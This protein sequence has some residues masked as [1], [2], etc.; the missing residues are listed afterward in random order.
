VYFGHLARLP[1]AFKTS[2]AEEPAMTA[3]FRFILACSL[4]LFV[5]QECRAQSEGTDPVERLKLVLRGAASDDWGRDEACKRQ[6]DSLH[7]IQDLHRALIL[8]EWRDLD[9][10]E[11]IAAIDRRNRA[12]IAERFDT[13][14]RSLLA[15]RNTAT[16]LAVLKLIAEMGV[17]AREVGGTSP[18]ARRFAPELFAILNRDDPALRDEA[19]QA[20]ASIRPDPRAAATVFEKLLRSPQKAKRTTAARALDSLIQACAHPNEHA[21]FPVST[22]ILQSELLQTTEAVARTAVLGLRDAEPAVRRPCAEAL[23]ES[24]AAF[25]KVAESACG[26]EESDGPG[27]SAPMPEPDLGPVLA[28]LEAACPP[29]T[30]ALA[31]ADPRIRLLSRQALEDLTNPQLHLLPAAPSDATAAGQGATQAG[32]RTVSQAKASKLSGRDSVRSR[33]GPARALAQGLNDP[34]PQARRA[35]IDLLE[36]MGPAALPASTALVK[37]LSDSDKFVCWSAARTL[38]KMSP[39]EQKTAVPALAKLLSHSDL[40]IQLAAAS[41]LT[42]YGPAATHAVDD[43]IRVLAADEHHQPVRPIPG[44]ARS[45][46]SSDPEL[47]VAVMAALEAIGNQALKSAAPTLRFALKNSDSRVRRKAAEALGKLNAPSPQSLHAL[48]AAL[49]D[50]APEVQKAASNALLNLAQ[51]SRGQGQGVKSQGSGVRGQGPDLR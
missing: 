51:Q 22:E 31:D 26:K 48:T 29:L 33:E 36:S 43:L 8:M 23:A 49:R 7:N 35:V 34:D 21:S 47:R 4:M 50:E 27:Q 40:D 44:A 37:A 12:L 15:Q 24:A 13:Q 6:I 9:L 14:I 16:K 17:S 10:Q 20:L 30:R 42:R 46:T 41:A 1:W 39:A 38:G 2:P 19:A 32:Y 25:R 45:T 28:A 11:S 18:Y 3:K 5:D